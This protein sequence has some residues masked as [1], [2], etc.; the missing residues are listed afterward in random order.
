ML[1]IGLYHL[2]AYLGLD[3]HLRRS[4][5]DFVACE[6]RSGWDEKCEGAHSFPNHVMF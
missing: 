5:V 1:E 4:G 2:N 6:K 3:T